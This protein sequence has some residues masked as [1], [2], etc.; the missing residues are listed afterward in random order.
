MRSLVVAL[1]LGHV[2]AAR[3]A[4][5]ITT[6][7]SGGCNVSEA[8][9]LE[10]ARALVSRGFAAAGYTLVGVDDCWMRET[11]D[12]DGNFRTSDAFPSGIE[13]LSRVPR[14]M[15]C[16]VPLE[17]VFPA[18]TFG[19][20]ALAAFVTTACFLRAR[21]AEGLAVG[22]FIVAAKRT[23]RLSGCVRRSARRPR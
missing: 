5:G 20:E 14:G 15:R 16:L 9:V 10:D 17:N 1:V 12:A 23:I 18:Q 21:A 19:V 11:R 3:P 13:N 7:M 6:W 8:S 22:V 2:G 4:M